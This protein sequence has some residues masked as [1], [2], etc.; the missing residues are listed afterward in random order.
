MKKQLVVLCLAVLGTVAVAA[1]SSSD[2]SSST[3]YKSITLGPAGAQVQVL[4]GDWEKGV[5]MNGR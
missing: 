2:D 1:C 4:Y 5:P 3:N